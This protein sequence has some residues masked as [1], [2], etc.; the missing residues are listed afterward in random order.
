MKISTTCI[1]NKKINLSIRMEEETMAPQL[2]KPPIIPLPKAS[3]VKQGIVSILGSEAERG[4]SSAPSIRRAFSADMSSKQWLAQNGFFSPMKRIASSKDLAVVSAADRSSSVDVWSSILSKKKDD[5]DMSN[6]ETPYIHPLVKRST[7]SLSEK[8]L[9]IC[10]ESLGSE[11]GSNSFSSYTPSETEDAEEE[12]KDEQLQQQQYGSESFEEFRA[13]KY[14]YSKKSSSFPKSFP[15]SISSLAKGDNK[16]SLHMQ[17]RREDGRLILE[18]ICIPPRNLFHA[19]CHNGR[20]LLTLIDDC[21]PTSLSQPEMEDYEEEFDEVFDDIDDQTPQFDYQSIDC[22]EQEEDEIE[23]EEEEGKKI[24]KEI[25]V[26]EQKPRLSS[27][28]INMKK[29]VPWSNKFNKAVNLTGSVCSTEL[30]KKLSQ[31]TSVPQS[32]PTQL[33]PSPPPPTAASGSATFNIYEYFWRKKPTIASIANSL[34][35]AKECNNFL[36]TNSTATKAE[37]TTNIAAF[38]QQHMVLMRGNNKENINYLVP[39]QRGCKEQKRSLLIWEPYCIA[40][41]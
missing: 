14:N 24:E 20:L 18:A 16:P 4:K 9:E 41:S 21:T 8:S 17:S 37:S 6:L 23:E 34:T 22:P 2:S 38:E 30:M 12:E 13:V 7:S 26:M 33:I 36:A 40:T 39:L 15:P 35:I 19:H 1:S 29:F 32:L 25:I 31:I 28:V 5:H 11:T 27:G 3:K 10:T